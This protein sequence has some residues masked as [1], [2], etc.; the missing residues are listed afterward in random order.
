MKVTSFEELSGASA[1]HKPL[2]VSKNRTGGRNNTGKMTMRYI[3]GGARKKVRVIDFKRNK[4][5]VPGIVKTVEYDPTRSAWV[6]LINYADGEKRY[7]ITPNGLK[8]DQ[9]IVSGDNAAP[10]IGNCLFIKDIPLGT[11]IHNIELRPGQGA[12]DV[13]KCRFICATSSKRRKVRYFKIAI[14]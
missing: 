7:I 8:V 1:P 14:R 11:L 4:L 13:K 2:L 10:E 3:G 5:G 6:S 9:T 12:K